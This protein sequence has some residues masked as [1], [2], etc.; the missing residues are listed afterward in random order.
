MQETEADC[1]SDDYGVWKELRNFRFTVNIDMNDYKFQD[2]KIASAI[3]T[4]KVVQVG[5]QKMT[6][7][8]FRQIEQVSWSSLY[9]D[10]LGFEDEMVIIANDFHDYG[11]FLG[12]VNEDGDNNKNWILYEHDKKLKRTLIP[13]KYLSKFRD[14]FDQLY[15][16]T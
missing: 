8:V 10:I 9:L 6:L 2:L 14:C 11:S 3:I 7:A 13:K 5:N 16:A 1:F 12:L 15:I 4:L